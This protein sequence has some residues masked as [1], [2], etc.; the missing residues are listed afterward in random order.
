V[1]ETVF[2]IDPICDMLILKL[3]LVDYFVL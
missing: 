2:V 3:L 1:F